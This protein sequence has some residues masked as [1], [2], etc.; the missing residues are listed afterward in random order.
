MRDKNTSKGEAGYGIVLKLMVGC[1]VK[2]RKLQVTD[3]MRRTATRTR[4]ECEK[5]SIRVGCWDDGIELKIVL[6]CGNEKAY[7]G[8]L[9]Q[10]G[11]LK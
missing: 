3:V 7:V 8:P 2:N 10:Y 9:R 5:H 11:D 4:R 1:G 6:G